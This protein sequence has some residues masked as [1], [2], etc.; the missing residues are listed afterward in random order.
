MLVRSIMI[1]LT[2]ICCTCIVQQRVHFSKY[3]SANTNILCSS[4]TM[5]MLFFCVFQLTLL[6][7]TIF[8]L[9]GKIQKPDTLVADLAKD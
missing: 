5:E 2:M 4:F 8:S 9:T 6:I 1:G 3:S 7:L